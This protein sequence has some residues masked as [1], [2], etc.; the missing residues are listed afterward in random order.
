[1][2]GCKQV[3]VVEDGKKQFDPLT[4]TPLTHEACDQ[5]TVV[6]KTGE[7]NEA[8]FDE[9]VKNL[10][11]FWPIRPTRTS[12]PPSV[13]VPTS[14]STWPSSSYSPISSSASTGRTCTNPHVRCSLLLELT[15]WRQLTAWPLSIGRRQRSVAAHVSYRMRQFFLQSPFR[16]RFGMVASEMKAEI[17]GGN[18]CEGCRAQWAP[19]G[20]KIFTA[21]PATM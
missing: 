13:S 2:I 16:D 19:A 3:Q 1:M 10:V 14:C 12:W 6:P 5:L 8:Q 15:L 21:S 18:A 17:Q 7:L 11:T 20:L 9:K 4:G